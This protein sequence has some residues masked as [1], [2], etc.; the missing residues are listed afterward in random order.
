LHTPNRL[1]RFP[2]PPRALP[3]LGRKMQTTVGKVKI[4]EFFSQ[5]QAS[6]VLKTKKEFQHGRHKSKPQPQK[7]FLH[8]AVQRQRL[9]ELYNVLEGT[10]YDDLDMIEINELLAKSIIKKLS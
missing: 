2:L 5:L 6:N 4:F 1:R 8:F 7:Q 9:P 3:L 10:S